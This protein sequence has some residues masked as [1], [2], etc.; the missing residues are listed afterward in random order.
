MQWGGL[1]QAPMAPLT[2]QELFKAAYYRYEVWAAPYVWLRDNTLSAKA[3]KQ[4]IT[5]ILQHYNHQGGKL[6]QQVILVTHSMG[7]LVARALTGIENDERVLGVVHEVLPGSGAPATYKRMRAGFE[8]AANAIL[9]R[10]AEE[11][12]AIM[13]TAPG[14]LQ[15]LP[16]RHYQQGK[17]WL[18]VM[19]RSRLPPRPVPRI[20]GDYR[21]AEPDALLA[22]PQADPYQEIY[23][24]RAW[25]GLIPEQSEALINPAKL[26]L[27]SDDTL[28][29]VQDPAELD[30]AP[31]QL[32][33]ARQ[34]FQKAMMKVE[35]FHSKIADHYHPHTYVHYGA[36]GP[37]LQH[38]PP[39]RNQSEPRLA[40]ENH[41]ATWQDVVW[42]GQV[43][44]D[45]LG[46]LANHSMDDNKTGQIS[47]GAVGNLQILPPDAPGDGTV[48]LASARDALRFLGKQVR[49]AFEHGNYGPP[50]QYNQHPGYEHQNSYID[51]W[52]RPLYAT[53][54]SIIKIAQDAT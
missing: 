49:G 40:V 7:G 8:G 3:I 43:Q 10:D 31:G 24:S 1:P 53:L 52:Q 34:A 39:L 5:D 17:P 45:P 36:E 30:N 4:T 42:L 28:Q 35:E 29:A 15:L 16:F 11:T 2:E 6:A 48:P 23:L 41:G 33:P 12:T 38:Y 26:K 20:G 18:K 22:L 54:Y 9:G 37:G 32:S 27:P 14:P 50:G 21:R 51:R 19:D 46:I 44:H 47:L 25:Y 13:A